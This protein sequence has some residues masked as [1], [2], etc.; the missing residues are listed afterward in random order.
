MALTIEVVT[1]FPDFFKGPLEES[2]LEKA[3]AKGLLKVRTHDLRKWT[4]DRHKTAD[5]KPFGGGAGMVMK[6]EP[7]FECVEE[8]GEDAWVVLMDPQGEPLSQALAAKLAKKK[9]L[10]LIAGHYEGVDQ[11]VKD[12]LVDQEISVGDFITMGG[13]APA[14]CLIEAVARLVPGV[15]GNAESIKHESFQT[16]ILEHPHYTRPREYR[17]WKVPDVLVSG[18]HK[19]VEAWRNKT[20]EQATRR[21]RP[22]LLE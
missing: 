13:E 5:D 14:L 7:I 2:L 20:A 18:D 10:V 16:G 4:H 3:Q 22:D 8:V 17:G 12:H 9:H 1:L 21:K 11:R 19:E 6:P 15:L